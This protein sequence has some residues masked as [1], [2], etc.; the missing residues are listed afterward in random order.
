M[1]LCGHS[2][3]FSETWPTSGMTRGG[4]AYELQTWEH[5]M[6]ASA[7]SS[8]P[9]LPTPQARDGKGE[10]ARVAYPGRVRTKASESLPDAMALL[11]TPTSQL[12]VNGGSQ[13]PEKR[14]EG[15]HGP[16]LADEVEHLLPT[17]QAHDSANPKTAEQVA[18]MRAQ[19]H[20][21]RNLN[22]VAA[23]ELLPTPSAALAS[24]GQTSRSG[25]RIGELLL[26]GIVQ[27]LA[28]GDPEP[29]LLPTPAANDSGN[30]PENHLRKKPGRQQVTSL[31]V[32]IDGDLLATGGR[33]R[34]EP[35]LPTPKTANRA[36]RKALTQEHWSAPGLEQALEIARGELPRELESWEELQGVSGASTPT[37]SDA[38]SD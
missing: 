13:H 9:V 4:S 33:L 24:G 14:R 23:N 8:S 28:A 38:G 6:A 7:S 11:K 27:A 18:A 35:L 31:Q 37:R 15:G 20:G 3:P 21:V 17:P 22:E 26:P 36:S 19:G 10:T 34:E 25:D 29:L 5:L 32:L 12:A 1:S 16:T 2:E 30:T